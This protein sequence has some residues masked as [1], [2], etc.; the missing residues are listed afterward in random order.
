MSVASESTHALYAKVLD[1]FMSWA[2]STK[3]YSVPVGMDRREWLV[4]HRTRELNSDDSV[5]RGH[6]ERVASLWM[7]HLEKTLD[8]L[9]RAI[10]VAALSRIFALLLPESFNGYLRPAE[11]DELIKPSKPYDPKLR[12]NDWLNALAPSTVVTYR[13][14]FEY[15]WEWASSHYHF[16][17]G[18]D[19]IDALR[20]HRRAEIAFD[21][22]T[23][24]HCEAVVHD[25]V[26]SLEKT[27]MSPESVKTYNR[28]I[29]S[30]FSHLH[31]HRRGRLNA[32]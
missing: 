18:V 28:V 16:P 24:G 11:P 26:S 8:P 31:G 4:A 12:T 22:K 25:W 9:T 2:S 17:P 27:D 3:H 30:F 20:E 10:Y 21:S 5:S 1:A 13:A 32:Q 15:W 14:V 6:C 19:P 7:D 23:K 29:R